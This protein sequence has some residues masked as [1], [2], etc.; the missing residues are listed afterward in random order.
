[1]LLE[2]VFCSATLSDERPAKKAAEGEEPCTEEGTGE[3]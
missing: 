1:M 2:A 3:G